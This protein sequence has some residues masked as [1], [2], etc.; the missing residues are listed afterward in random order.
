[1]NSG[2]VPEENG[3]GKKKGP[4]N[5][6]AKASVFTDLFGD[7]KYLIQLYRALHPE[8]VDVTEDQIKNVTIQNILLDRNY[9]DLGFQIE[10]R[11]VIL[12]EAQSTWTVNIIVRG[13]MYLVQT[14]Q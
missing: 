7:K 12:I 4:A 9:N 14:Y 8:D 2:K 3:T 5:R 1:M 6:T 11:L 10:D 13:L